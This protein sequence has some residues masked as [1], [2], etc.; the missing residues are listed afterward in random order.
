[1]MENLLAL[2]RDHSDYVLGVAL[3]VA[4]YLGNR[5]YNEMKQAVA[6]LND[7]ME[8]MVTRESYDAFKKHMYEKMTE[9]DATHH[10]LNLRLEK[11]ITEHKMF[12]NGAKKQTSLEG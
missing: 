4:F 7:E 9:M 6:D 1:M 3:P 11:L 2:W 5:Y 12:H 8:D 10:A